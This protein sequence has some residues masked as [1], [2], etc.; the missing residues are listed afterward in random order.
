[1]PKIAFVIPF[2]KNLEFLNQAI[3][4]VTAQTYKDWELLIVDDCGPDHNAKYLVD[5][6]NDSRISYFRNKVNLGLAENWN[7]C[8]QKGSAPFITILHAD[9]TLHDTYAERMV[10]Y[11]ELYT[12][13][14]AIFCR[15]NIINR[16]N[17]RILSPLDLVKY[18]FFTPKF[19]NP[20]LL[21]GESG[22][23]YLAKANFIYCPTLCYRRVKLG[24]NRFIPELKFVVDYEF[25]TRLILN[26]HQILSIPEKLF[27][28]RRHNQSQTSK[29]TESNIRFEEEIEFYKDLEIKCDKKNW[30]NASIIA[31]KMLVVKLALATKIVSDILKGNFKIA[32][33][34]KL[35]T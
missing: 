29:L 30:I 5:S 17:K 24:N 25:T 4:S 23:V 18:Y 3:K 15:V 2:F 11:M 10:K 8:L 13:V 34:R 12:D 31:K 1:M 26:N 21:H 27:N 32:Y 35:L 14:S 7:I 20:H 6:F 22:M 19:K 16:S 28:Y 9:D 33:L